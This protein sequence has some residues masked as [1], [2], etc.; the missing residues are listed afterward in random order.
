MPTLDPMQTQMRDAAR[1]TAVPQIPDVPVHELRAR[2]AAGRQAV[3]P[4]PAMFEV[5]ETVL[6]RG[7]APVRLRRYRPS[8]LEP[9][10]T[11]LFVHSGGWVVGDLD[12]SD[13]EV[14]HLARA[15]GCE[16][17]SVE[18]R[19][20]P[21]NPFPAAVEDVL[22]AL[23]FTAAL[24]RP[25]VIHGDS[26][27]GNLAAVAARVARDR[28]IPIVV[29]I[30]VY[31]VVTPGFDTPSYTERSADGLLSAEEMRWFWDQYVPDVGQRQD[32]HVDLMVAEITG[33][34]PAHVVIAEFDVLRD[35]GRA[36]ASALAAAGVRVTVREFDDC[37]HGFIGL[38]GIL[39]QADRCIA[40]IGEV[41]RNAV[42][43]SVRG[44]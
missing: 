43:A 15:S 14:R 2:I 11:V 38:P 13:A 23:E 42:A 28:G 32:P 35:E 4:G 17:V 12:G 44:C 29:Q 22:S 18:Y 5:A 36:Y 9:S 21:E 30:L 37:S 7:S 40:E 39:P 24:G 26:A 6:A 10:G 34:A 19:L 41:V 33:V 20:A 25:L 31:P 1:D 8:Q 16:Y 3:P 27:G